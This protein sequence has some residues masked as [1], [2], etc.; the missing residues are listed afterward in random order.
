MACGSVSPESWTLAVRFLADDLSHLHSGLILLPEPGFPIP[1]R[2]PRNDSSMPFC[3][4][5][6]HQSGA[7]DGPLGGPPVNLKL[8]V[9]SFLPHEGLREEEVG[10]A[11]LVRGSASYEA[12]GPVYCPRTRGDRTIARSRRQPR[13]VA[14]QR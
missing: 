1:P 2:L 7:M 8:G 12:R 11:D 4:K 3:G 9:P 10:N 14:D 13:V 5:G 6:C